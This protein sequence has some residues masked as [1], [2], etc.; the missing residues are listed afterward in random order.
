LYEREITDHHALHPDFMNFSPEG[1]SIYVM[2]L[3]K[4]SLLAWYHLLVP[5]IE[6]YSQMRRMADQSSFVCDVFFLTSSLMN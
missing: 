6:Q 5:V 4:N 2:C 3:L 1:C